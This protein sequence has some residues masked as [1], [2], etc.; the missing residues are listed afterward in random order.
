[1]A[2][3]GHSRSQS[4]YVC[5]PIEGLKVLQNPMMCLQKTRGTDDG[6]IQVKEVMPV[7]MQVSCRNKLSPPSI[8][9]LG[10]NERPEG[11]NMEHQERF[12]GK[13]DPLCRKLYHGHHEYFLAKMPN[14]YTI[15]GPV[16]SWSN[17]ILA[18]LDLELRSGPVFVWT[19][20]DW[21]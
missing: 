5:F 17:Q 18:D 19:G 8:N 9:T 12:I 2:Q 13:G 1:M 6:Q 11:K 14:R 3:A 15:Q 10:Y 20:S 21:V 16:W 4:I 7:R